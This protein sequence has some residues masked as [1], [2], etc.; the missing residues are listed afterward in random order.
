MPHILN[1]LAPLN[2]LSTNRSGLP[3]PFGNVKLT[4]WPVN[5]PSESTPMR[6]F[7]I[8]ST[9]AAYIS[10]MV[11]I[12]SRYSF[13]DLPLLTARCPVLC[14]FTRMCSSGDASLPR[15]ILITSYARAF[16]TPASAAIQPLIFSASEPPTSSDMSSGSDSMSRL[17]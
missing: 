17:K 16:L 11:L 3:M 1:G 4:A 2:I 5:A 8:F 15:L 7:S 10:D 13:I 9:A 12:M 6:H 14:T